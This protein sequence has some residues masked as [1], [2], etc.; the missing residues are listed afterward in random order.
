[1]VLLLKPSRQAKRSFEESGLRFRFTLIR[2]Y[3]I[4]AQK[5]LQQA[6]IHLFP[7]IP[8][9]KA[10]SRA[11]WEAERRIYTSSLPVAEK[12]DLL[13]AM[14][15]F[16]G[17]T[18]TQLVRQLVERRRDLM[19]QSYAYEII[20]KE[21][22]DEGM[23]QG[24]QQGFQRGMQHGQLERAKKAVADALEARLNVVPL[25]VITALKTIEDVQIL[26]ELLRKAVIVKDMQEFRSLLKQ[27]LEPA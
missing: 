7:F 27:I 26:E 16:A 2:L 21:G 24:S 23:Q 17:L 22:F 12:A 10:S 18:N 8:V 4:S 20:K 11:V 1:V 13:T 14:T 15:I 25:D 19:I 3:R 5:F 9:M 6:D